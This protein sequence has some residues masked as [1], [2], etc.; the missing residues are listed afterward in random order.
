MISAFDT[1]LSLLRQSIL[2]ET[3]V[4]LRALKSGA[5]NEQLQSIAHRIREKEHRLAREE[6]AVLDPTMWRILH[7]RLINRKVEFID[8]NN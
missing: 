6:G 7:S 1:N 4:F 8:L 2:A 3:K 5:S